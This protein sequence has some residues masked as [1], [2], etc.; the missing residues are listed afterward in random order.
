MRITRSLEF[1]ISSNEEKLPYA[2]AAF[3]YIAS[4]TGSRS[5]RGTG[6]TP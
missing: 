5:C 1:Q 4:I 6:T 2:T 3:P